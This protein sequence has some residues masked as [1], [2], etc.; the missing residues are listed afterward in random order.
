MDVDSRAGLSR[1][2]SLLRTDQIGFIE[3]RFRVK[4]E[5]DVRVFII[6]QNW[7]EIK[8]YLTGLDDK[9]KMKF[10]GCHSV[11]CKNIYG[12]KACLRVWAFRFS[13]DKL[14]P[15]GFCYLHEWKAGTKAGEGL[16]VIYPGGSDP[17]L[18]Q[19]LNYHSLGAVSDTDV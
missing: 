15:H 11:T 1:V 17:F 3:R 8:D 13:E 7:I 4:P 14:W 2:I 5:K 19:V 9:C 12:G 6:T 18:N 10:S 16:L